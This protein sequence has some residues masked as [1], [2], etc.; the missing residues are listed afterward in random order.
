[1]HLCLVM[2]SFELKSESRHKRPTAARY[3][4]I[5]K[6]LNFELKERLKFGTQAWRKCHEIKWLLVFDVARL[7]KNMNTEQLSKN[8]LGKYQ[9]LNIHLNLKCTYNMYQFTMSELHFQEEFIIY[10]SNFQQN[11]IKTVKCPIWD[12]SPLFKMCNVYHK[13]KIW[14]RVLKHQIKL[15]LYNIFNCRDQ[16][17]AEQMF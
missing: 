3:L 5:L 4:L 1:M 11:C 10:N 12:N 2:M 14:Y 15:H 13:L 9:F 17:F 7:P 8:Y 16:V 6:T